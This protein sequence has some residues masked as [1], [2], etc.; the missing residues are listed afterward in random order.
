MRK[1][2][3]FMVL[4]LASLTS[5]F[6]QD[7][8][9]TAV[10]ASD[11]EATWYYIQFNRGEGIV[12]T[13]GAGSM[14][15]TAYPSKE[16]GVEATNHQ[17]FKLVG[18]KS[19]FALISKAGKSVVY[20][21]NRFRVQDAAPTTFLKLYNQP[22][23]TGVFQ[24]QAIGQNDTQGM[25]P[26]GGSF[27]ERDLG[28]WSVG[29]GGN[30]LKFIPASEA[31]SLKFE[32]T[33]NT[34]KP[35][36]VST[37]DAN[38]TQWYQIR[39]IR[40]MGYTNSWETGPVVMAEGEGAGVKQKN[41]ITDKTNTDINA[42]LWQF[43]GDENSFELVNKN[44]QHAYLDGTIK[45][46]K[47]QTYQFSMK[48]TNRPCYA[49]VALQVIAQNGRGMNANGGV[50]VDGT[51]GVWNDNDVNNML[52]FVPVT[53]PR[54]IFT[55][56]PNVPKGLQ[57][58]EFL[59][60]NDDVIE[61]LS[62]VEAGT[63]VKVH[64]KG[65]LNPTTMTVEMGGETTNILSD[66][67]SN[68]GYSKT[69]TVTG[70]CTVTVDGDEAWPTALK[71]VDGV[72]VRVFP[73]PAVDLVQLSGLPANAK[74]ALIAVTGQT[75]LETKTNVEGKATLNVAELAGGLY[76]LRS[77]KFVAKLQVR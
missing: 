72:A 37:F 49:G 27:F 63:V 54:T 55:I 28:L 58:V 43:V 22:S 21:N 11:S 67:P 38:A 7:P 44:G 56:T 60:E 40:Q 24:I 64:V 30:P 62:Q 12:L 20:N 17:L 59:N 19:S 53:M 16:A 47:T 35:T 15:K 25:N 3:L 9:F 75:V 65:R 8:T 4:V 34:V 26:I 29:D 46:S 1:F 77:G 70:D 39:F 71:T 66:D 14:L 41:A 32:P 23:T 6:A 61:D 33:A 45:A 57:L 36:F 76:I 68:L 10:G 13:T 2:Y 31:S 18:T 74:V 42:Q 50:G 48:G 52:R 5:V 69:F 51:V 73:N